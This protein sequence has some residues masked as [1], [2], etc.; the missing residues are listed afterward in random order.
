MQDKSKIPRKCIFPLT[1]PHKGS[2]LDFVPQSNPVNNL[3]LLC[4]GSGNPQPIYPFSQLR[5]VMF[6]YTISF[7]LQKSAPYLKEMGLMISQI[8]IASNYYRYAKGIKSFSSQRKTSL[9]L[10][11]SIIERQPIYNFNSKFTANNANSEGKTIA[12]TWE[13]LSGIKSLRPMKQRF[14]PR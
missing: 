11:D 1:N 12:R 13:R 2:I 6:K 7:K 3:I 9:L 5:H 14:N 8:L 4:I 10:S